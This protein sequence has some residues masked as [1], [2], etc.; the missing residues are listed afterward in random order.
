MRV[1]A[2][3]KKKNNN[4]SDVKYILCIYVFRKSCAKTVKLFMQSINYVPTK[5][6]PTSIIDSNNFIKID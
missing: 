3:K 6:L 5:L 2:A 1:A 4:E